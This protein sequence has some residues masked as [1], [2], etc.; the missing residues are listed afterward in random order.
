[1]G[2][3][4]E[5]SNQ[6]TGPILIL[7]QHEEDLLR[8]LPRG[9]DGR[10]WMRMAEVSLQRDPSLLQAAANDVGRMLQEFHKCAALGHVPNSSDAYILA[11][12]EKGV[13][14]IAF[15]E[16][17]KGLISRVLRTGLYRKVVAE[18]VHEN[19]QIEYDPA[20]DE[21][22]RHS[23]TLAQAGRGKPQWAYAY[24]VH[25]DGSIG[26]VSIADADRIAKARASSPGSGSKYSPWQ[27]NPEAMFRKTAIHGL[28]GFVETSSEDLR[29]SR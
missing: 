25:N 1:M 6:Q 3:I 28:D 26:Y 11:R 12:R 22:P 5:Q 8:A 19:D 27:T 17:Y 13:E 2:S 20:V 29:R 10:V 18:V 9:V 15:S 7:K 4:S 21:A 14:K 24:A 23:W 16:S